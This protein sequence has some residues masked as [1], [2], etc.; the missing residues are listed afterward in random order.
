MVAEL[1]A[2]PY[3]NSSIARSVDRLHSAFGMAQRKGAIVEVPRKYAPTHK[4]P[5]KALTPSQAARLI[6]GQPNQDARDL[7]MV[8]LATGLRIGEALALEVR[9]L[10][11]IAQAVLIDGTYQRRKGMTGEVKTGNSEAEVYVP[12]EGWEV[13]VRR[14]AGYP[15][16]SAHRLFLRPGCRVVPENTYRDWFLA[17]VRRLEA[18]GDFPAEVTFH[19]MRHTHG[20]WLLDKK[21]T[22]VAVADRLRNTPQV[23]ESTY[24]RTSTAAHVSM[25]G[26]I[27][28]LMGQG[29]DELAVRRRE[30]IRATS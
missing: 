3:A 4:S 20:G 24:A 14:A 7:V 9:D 28:E 5:G 18:E 15:S 10:K 6:E 17:A 25:A 13:L 29:S 23:V 1:Q 30:A 26:D 12:D 8:L 21:W 19:D 16:T 2:H 11:P 22:A 27:S